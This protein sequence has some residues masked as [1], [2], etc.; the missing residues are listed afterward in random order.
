MNK[1]ENRVAVRQVVQQAVIRAEQ[2]NRIQHAATNPI[3]E[4]LKSLLTT[5]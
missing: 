5:L 4:V 3:K 2:N 1:K